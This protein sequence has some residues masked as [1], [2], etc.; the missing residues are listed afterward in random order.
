MSLSQALKAVRHKEKDLYIVAFGDDLEVS[1]RLPSIRK[2]RQY[3]LMLQ[4][5]EDMA[6]K[7]IIYEDLFRFVVTDPFFINCDD[8]PAGIPESIAGLVLHLSGM[9][10]NEAALELTEALLAKERNEKNSLLSFMQRTI[11]G[12]FPAYSFE[13]LDKLTYP[14]L[15][16]VFVNA[17]QVLIDVGKIEK[18]WDIIGSMKGEDQS[19][20]QSSIN[21]QIMN[22]I[23]SY[24]EF[25]K[26]MGPNPMIEKLR[27]EAMERTLAEEERY[28]EMR[29][30]SQR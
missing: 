29:G 20:T 6:L 7:S 9:S 14:E 28:K 12:V 30:R 24:K 16:K 25:D 1:F 17:E 15:V 13:A 19:S 23:N 27:R 5:S 2:I 18:E 8:I 21:N 4:L 11:C 22:D 3:A 26:P 10:S